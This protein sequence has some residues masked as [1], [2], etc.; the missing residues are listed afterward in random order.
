M[1]AR[2]RALAERDLDVRLQIERTLA[3]Y[4]EARARQGRTAR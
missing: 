4:A 2:A 1:G 3:V